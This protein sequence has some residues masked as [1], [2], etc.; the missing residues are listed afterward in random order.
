MT[1]NKKGPVAA[2]DQ[3]PTLYAKHKANFIRLALFLIAWRESAIMTAVI[4]FTIGLLLAG[5]WGH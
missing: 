3:A 4:G 5:L 2:N 1:D